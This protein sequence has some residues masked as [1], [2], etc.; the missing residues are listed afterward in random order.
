MNFETITYSLEGNVA[1]ITLARPEK[2]NAF[3]TRMMAELLDVLDQTD[4]DDAVR[5]IILTGEGRAFCSGADLSGGPKTFEFSKGGEPERETTKVNGIYRDGGGRVTMR[6]FE[7]LKPVIAAINGPAIGAGATIPLAADIRIASTTARFGF[8]FA[9][10]GIVP[11]AAASWFLTRHV[12]VQTALAWCLGGRTVEAE[13]ALHRN[14]VFSLHEPDQLM[15]AAR[16]LAL[17]I[18]E[19]AAPLSASLTRQMFWRLAAAEHPMAAHRAD[20]RAIQMLGGTQDA[21]EA[22]AAFLE[23]RAPVFTGRVSSEMP[24]IWPEWSEPVFR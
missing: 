4:R 9:R 13:E 14:L 6:M 2:L 16:E 15:M 19:Q 17:E 5:A 24:N 23:K 21:R 1:T 18:A 8:V 3:N 22:L 11:E 10:R 12:G 20:S 7:S